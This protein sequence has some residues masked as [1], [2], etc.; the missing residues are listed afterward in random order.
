[1]GDLTSALGIAGLAT[2]GPL[3]ATLLIGRTGP[4][5]GVRWIGLV[6]ATWLIAAGASWAIGAGRPL[7]ARLG[8]LAPLAAICPLL[9]AA[10]LSDRDF[11]LLRLAAGQVVAAEVALLAL[12]I[13]AAL[14]AFQR[15]LSAPG[16]PEVARP[17]GHPW[18]PSTSAPLAGVALMLFLNDALLA[19]L[20]SRQAVPVVAVLPVALICVAV[21]ALAARPESNEVAGAAGL[22]ALVGFA[23]T[24]AAWLSIGPAGMALLLS[25][26]MA[27]LALVFAAQ[28]GFWL[29]LSRPA[30]VLCGT[31]LVL[32]CATA[33]TLEQRFGLAARE[34]VAHVPDLPVRLPLAGAAALAAALALRA[35]GPAYP[36]R[37]AAIGGMRDA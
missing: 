34:L 20:G 10:Y 7:R 28:R 9:I 37:S 26:V 36:S 17:V 23:A 11:H 29:V 27:A 21:L 8:P 32:G 13:A 14:P 33:L 35:A 30:A 12:G 16:S 22:V 24:T 6:A 3:T 15:W 19:A 1:M 5:P 25:R 4:L 2:C 31:L 18:A